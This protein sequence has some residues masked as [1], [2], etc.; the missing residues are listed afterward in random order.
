MLSQPAPPAGISFHA[1]L[2][3]SPCLNLPLLAAAFDLST[4]PSLLGWACQGPDSLFLPVWGN[5]HQRAHTST[6][7][8]L[9]SQSRSLSRSANYNSDPYPTCQRMRPRPHQAVFVWLFL[10]FTYFHFKERAMERNGKRDLPYT[11]SLSMEGVSR[12]P[13]QSFYLLILVY[14]EFLAV[15]L[16]RYLSPAGSLLLLIFNRCDRACSIHE[17]SPRK[18]LFLLG[19]SFLRSL[20]WG[21]HYNNSIMLRLLTSWRPVSP[22]YHFQFWLFNSQSSPLVIC[23]GKQQRMA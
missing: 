5:Y 15:C 22:E 20:G 1:C 7:T 19:K 3:C 10:R 14:P 11:C 16:G 18:G 4:C 21:L 2:G 17:L 13:K 9:G 23:L 6:V 8:L 12:V